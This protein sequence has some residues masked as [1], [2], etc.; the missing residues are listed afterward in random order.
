MKNVLR[1]FLWIAVAVLGFAILF[2]LYGRIKD[3]KI[4]SIPEQNITNYKG[5][6]TDKV[7]ATDFTLKDIEGNTVKL[8]DFRGKKVILNF[9]ASWCPPCKAE[10]PDIQKV[11]EELMKANEA[12]VLSIDL[13]N[14]Y[15]GETKEQGAK[16]FKKNGFTYRVVFDNDSKVAMEYKISSIPTTYFINKDGTIFDNVVYYA[17]TSDKILGGTDY[18]TIMDNINR[19]E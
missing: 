13:S 15:N 17:G 4:S 18:K 19:M 6:N 16:Y 1:M 2:N 7:M 9:W 11:H 3:N 8:S 12:V 10:M 14:G 5:D